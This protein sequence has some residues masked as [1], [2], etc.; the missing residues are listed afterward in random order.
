MA[1]KK[2]VL[3]KNTKATKNVPSAKNEAVVLKPKNEF[4]KWEKLGSLHKI[5]TDTYRIHDGKR[6][7]SK[8]DLCE[9]WECTDRTVKRYIE[10]G[11]PQAENLTTTL[12]QVFYL[13][14]CEKWRSQN[15]DG[16]KQLHTLPPRN[17]EITPDMMS[18]LES[19]T[20]LERKLKADADKAEADAE[21]TKIKLSLAQG[22]VVNAEDLDKSM[23]EL[24]VIHKTDLT[25]QEK[26]F[27]ISLANKDANEIAKIVHE[28]NQDRL[29]TLDMLMN[30]EFKSK[31]GLYEIISKVLDMLADDI[32]PDTI[33]E[34]IK[35]K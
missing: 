32:E 30:K 20:D 14:D 10:K 11:M 5:R 12:F 1:E 4:A 3:A 6:I 23:A 35:E 2:V 15:I 13:T 25:N 24:A 7:V 8:Q 29:K 22:D 26:I 27:P 9:I 28:Y 16:T 18:E 19:L 34:R 31:N 21:L 33:L 17:K